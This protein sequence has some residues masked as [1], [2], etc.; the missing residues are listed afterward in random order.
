LGK[1]FNNFKEKVEEKTIVLSKY[2][3]NIMREIERGLSTI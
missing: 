1:K 2:L 3:K